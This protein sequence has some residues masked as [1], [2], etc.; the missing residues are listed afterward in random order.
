MITSIESGPGGTASTSLSVVGPA[1]LATS[2]T[3]TSIIAGNNSQIGFTVTN[4]NT[5]DLTGVGFSDSLPPGLKVATPNNL[6]STCGGT[7]IAAPGSSSISLSGATVTASSNCTIT[8]DVTA[9]GSGT[10]NN[11]T[12]R[13]HVDEPHPERQHRQRV[14][15]AVAAP[16]LATSFGI[17]SIKVGASTTATFTIQNSNAFTSLTGVGFSDPLPAGLKVATPNGLTGSC[18]GGTI[19]AAAGSSS[20][21]LSGATLAAST[22]C[23]FSVNVTGTA[24]G[25]QT[26]TTGAVTSTESGAAATASAV[27]NVF[28]APT[29]SLSYADSTLALNSTTQMTLTIGNP[30]ANPANLTGVGVTDPLPTGLVVGTPPNLGGSCAGTVTAIAGSSTVSVSGASI[31]PGATC[32]VIV[33]VKGTT[34]GPTTNTTG[35]VTSTEGGTGG[36]ASAPLTV[37]LAPTLHISFTPSTINVGDTSSLSFNV[38]NNNG[39][40]LTGIA[41]TDAL[42]A[43]MTI[44]PAGLTGT[45]GGGTITATV[46]T[47]QVNLSGATIPATGNCT[48]TVAVTT[49]TL[50]DS[51]NTTSQ[52][53]SSSGGNGSAATATLHLTANAP[54]IALAYGAPAIALNSTTT[55]TMTITNPATNPGTLHNVSISDS[56]PS[57]IKVGSPPNVSNSC[58]GGAVTAVANSSTVSL[59]GGT[60]APGASCAV[61]VDVKGT[62]VGTQSNT[63]GN[64]SATESG[65][66]L[67]ASAS[68]TVALAPTLAMT[69]TPSSITVGQTSTI[70]FT[71]GNTN[72]AALTGVA[73]TDTLPAG[74]TI[75]P[76]G[77]TGTCGG[78]TITAAVGTG[79]INLSGAT[80]PAS[81]NC[82]F[83]VAVSTTALGDSVNT[84]SQVSS[85]NGGNG[86]SANATLHLTANAPTVALAYGAPAIAKNSTT[87]MTITITNPASN[88]GTLH[89][90]SIS[91]SLPSDITVGTPSNISNSCG[92]TATAVDGGSSVSLS[93]GTLA[94]GLPCAVVVD[95]KGVTVGTQSNTTGNVS[96]TE[97]GNGL[98]ASASLTVALAPTLAMTFTPNSITVGQ[99]STINFTVGNTNAAALTGVAFTDA[100]PTGMTIATGGLTGS[101]GG[102]VITAVDGSNQISLSGAT[103]PASGNC[104]FAVKVTTNT[105]GPSVNTT[106]QVSSSSGGNGAAATATL[107]VA[108]LAPTI[109]LSFANPSI[110]LN[111]TTSMTLTI[112]N[113]AGNPGNLTGVSVSDTLPAGLVVATPP[114]LGGPCNGTVTATAGASSVSVSGASIIPGGTCKLIVDVQGTTVGTKNNTTGTVASTEGGSGGTANASLT[115]ALAPS[116]SMSFTPSSIAS[117]GTSTLN[118]TVQNTN[119][120]SLTGIAFTDTLP[121]GMTIAAS[122]LTGSCGGGTITAVDGSNEV[123]LAGATIAASG[124]CSVHRQGDLVD[125]RLGRQ[126]D[127][128]DL[129]VQRR[130]RRRGE[131]DAPGRPGADR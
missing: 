87:Q 68:L 122:G 49:T 35:T 120:V 63:T 94:A 65:N 46:G 48:F 98:T 104:T 28:A 70:N 92:G 116:L 113:P 33:D 86:S 12:N 17:G 20:I 24:A 45:C 61:I 111:T 99:T 125:A 90:V 85:T 44:A 75:A 69:F 27:V 91:D 71:V 126:H 6:S 95:V 11:T 43:G 114:N 50:G 103:I 76:A 97:S 58:P 119:A 77:L 37:A 30:S 112:S 7:V 5:V 18:G 29:I 60:L 67:T 64:V 117:G 121:A 73:F 101:C 129:V 96:A 74:M 31:A 26:N 55:M 105:Y 57:D 115:V 130:Q 38:Q 83:T 62:T 36:T 131:R 32:T 10:F 127:I 109:S 23:T 118:Y 93:G 47:G 124:S 81:G 66:G 22:N 14:A 1:S 39:V 80:I 19:T 25:A 21:S 79:Q 9:P 59:S 128:A 8:A 51:V 84:T 2:F 100:L 42:P 16:T 107:Q 89:N 110:A 41:F 53:T 3:P 123:D 72:A 54:T 82:T 88:P 13:D 34:V 102:G 56:L 4:P 106:S 108:M 15:A 40:S 52:V 78:G